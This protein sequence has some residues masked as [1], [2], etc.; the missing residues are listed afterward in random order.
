M[1]HMVY[2]SETMN[3]DGLIQSVPFK[4]Y[5]KKLCERL[6]NANLELVCSLWR[7]RIQ[8]ACFLHKSEIWS[9]YT[10]ICTVLSFLRRWYRDA[11]AWGCTHQT[12]NKNSLMTLQ[13]ALEAC[14]SPYRALQR[15]QTWCGLS[16]QTKR[17]NMNKVS[18]WFPFKTAAFTSSRSISSS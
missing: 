8:I 7:R 15:R 17:C 1:K 2:H 4:T 9:K 13:H 5:D 6:F 18:S 3:L 16:F 14:L 12:S 10:T 11:S